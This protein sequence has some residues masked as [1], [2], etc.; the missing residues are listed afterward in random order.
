MAILYDAAH[1]I[2]IGV[3]IEDD[4][5]V[6]DGDPENLTASVPAEAG[7]IEDWMNSWGRGRGISFDRHDLT[8]RGKIGERTHVYCMTYFKPGC[9]TDETLIR[10]LED[11]DGVI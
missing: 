1:L 9:E 8:Y 6:T 10:A 7:A 4:I 3:R 2:G 5:R 11:E